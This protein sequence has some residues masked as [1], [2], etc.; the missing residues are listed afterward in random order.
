M[1]VLKIAASCWCPLR[2]SICVSL[3]NIREK[4]TQRGITLQ[5]KDDA[6]L[7]S[8]KMLSPQDYLDL[9]KP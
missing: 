3:E 8:I 5:D 7:K 1:Q 9:M 4:M 6:V 2:S